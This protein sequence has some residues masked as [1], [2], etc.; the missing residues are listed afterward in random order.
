MLFPSIAILYDGIHG[1]C[2]AQGELSDAISP[3]GKEA[4][5]LISGGFLALAGVREYRD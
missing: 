3:I 2:V 4:V 5:A 1:F